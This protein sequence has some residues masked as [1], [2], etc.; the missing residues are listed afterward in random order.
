MKVFSSLIKRKILG[1]AGEVSLQQI[2]HTPPNFTEILA[3]TRATWSRNFQWRPQIFGEITLIEMSL[4]KDFNLLIKALFVGYVSD[5]SPQVFGDTPPNY[6]AK[7][8]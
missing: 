6:R 2:V 8:Y 3:M 5:Y 7:L 4:W 1:G